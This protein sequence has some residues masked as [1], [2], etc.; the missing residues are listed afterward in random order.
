MLFVILGLTVSSCSK[1]DKDEPSAVAGSI[2]VTNKSS[3]TLD[4]FRVNFT[5][6][7]GETITIEQKGTLK[8]E[9]SVTVEA[10]IGATYYYMSTV[11]YGDRYFSA[12]YA[13]SVK[14]QVL[15]DQIVGQWK[16]N[17]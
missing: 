17:Y 16:K 15:S 8:P 2:R 3:Y 14:S 11:M 10:P 5:N 12:D 13:I 1:D 6:D 4:D 9:A 7:K